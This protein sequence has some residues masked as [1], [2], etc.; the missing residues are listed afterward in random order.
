VWRDLDLLGDEEPLKNVD[1]FFA[2]MVDCWAAKLAALLDLLPVLLFDLADPVAVP[3]LMA[4]G[5]E[6]EVREAVLA[7]SDR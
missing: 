7:G 1:F 5:V 2:L 3:D 6:G 4:L